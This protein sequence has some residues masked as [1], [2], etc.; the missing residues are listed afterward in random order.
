MA[1][2]KKNCNNCKYGYLSSV[3]NKPTAEICGNDFSQWDPCI[4]EKEKRKMTDKEIMEIV[5]KAQMLGRTEAYVH[6]FH[7][8]TDM[9][10][11]D[12]NENLKKLLSIITHKVFHVESEE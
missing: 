2:M 12:D 3:C 7:I 6:M 9:I 10:L 1:E 11:T 4:V 8:V 5:E